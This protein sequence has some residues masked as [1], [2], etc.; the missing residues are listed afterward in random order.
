MLDQWKHWLTTKIINLLNFSLKEKKNV[1][2]LI[3]LIEEQLMIIEEG[4]DEWRKVSDEIFE[5]LRM[6]HY[7]LQ[8]NIV[9]MGN[10]NL[11]NW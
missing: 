3:M 11:F 9:L 1:E 4:S 6:Y 10:I 5:K 8:L 7:A 2:K